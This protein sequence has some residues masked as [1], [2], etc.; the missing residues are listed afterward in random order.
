MKKALVFFAIILF[1]AATFATPIITYAQGFD[2]PGIGSDGGLVPCGNDLTKGE[3]NFCH[4]IELIRR[5]FKFLIYLAA[6][7]VTLLIAWAGIKLMVNADNPSER[8]SAKTLLKDALVGFILMLMAGFIVNLILGMLVSSSAR[9]G[10]NW[11]WG[12]NLKCENVIPNM[13]VNFLYVEGTNQ[14]QV[15]GQ[16][17]GGIDYTSPMSQDAIVAGLR[18]TS[19][20]DSMINEVSSRYGIPPERIKAIIAAESSGNAGAVSPVGA[21][22]LTQLM[23]DTAKY[24]DKTYFG[25]RYLSGLNDTD[26]KNKLIENPQIAIELGVAY[27]SEALKKTGEDYTNASAYYN[28]GPNAVA[29]SRNCPGL[30]AWQCKYDSSGCYVNGQ[31]IGGNCKLNQGPKSFAQTRTYTQNINAAEQLIRNKK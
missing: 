16:G 25:G 11:W 19:Q 9:A 30:Q 1:L 12:G 28:G 7:L 6:P 4:L 21:I 23:P 17:S 3:C 13:D 27:Y 8:E 5:V 22:G 15:V 24:V 18:K 29:P 20:Y 31:D 10:T 2:G 14:V 26:L